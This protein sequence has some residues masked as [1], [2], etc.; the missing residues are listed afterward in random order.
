LIQTA[1]LNDVDPQA[2][3]ADVLASAGSFGEA[4]QRSPALELEVRAPAKSRCVATSNKINHAL[5]T[6][7]SAVFTGRVHFFMTWAMTNTPNNR[8]EP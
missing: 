8:A 5:S 7:I 3:L 1:K 6:I 4:D 2:W